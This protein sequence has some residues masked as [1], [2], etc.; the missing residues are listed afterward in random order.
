[1]CTLQNMEHQRHAQQNHGAIT[2][3]TDT[4]QLLHTDIWQTH[5]LENRTIQF[6]MY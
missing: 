4:A 2:A 1:M 5:H 6:D 3:T